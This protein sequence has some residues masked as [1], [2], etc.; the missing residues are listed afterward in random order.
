MIRPH[1]AAAPEPTAAPEASSGSAAP[2]LEAWAASLAGLSDR[3]ERIEE[4][5]DDLHRP[6]RPLPATRDLFC[7]WVRLRR[8]E[9]IP[10]GDFLR[11]RRAGLL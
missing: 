1:A 9:E 7:E 10:F 8:W 3:L 2:A 4:R 5:V 6:V 11:L